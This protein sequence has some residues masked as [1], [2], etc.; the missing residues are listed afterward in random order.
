M[1]KEALQHRLIARLGEGKQQ[2]DPGR[3]DSR[4][5]GQGGS[6]LLRCHPGL[7]HLYGAQTCR[8]NLCELENHTM[9]PTMSNPFESD[10]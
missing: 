4:F 7:I 1:R 10:G 8:S 6:S 9:D 2:L 5:A 3:P